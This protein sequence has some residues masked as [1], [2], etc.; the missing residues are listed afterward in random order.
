LPPFFK[1]PFHQ[2]H[3]I[4]IIPMWPI[5]HRHDVEEACDADDVEDAF[6]TD[7]NRRYIV[8]E[9]VM[10]EQ[11]YH[12]MLHNLH[13]VVALI[14]ETS[15]LFVD[16]FEPHAPTFQELY[17]LIDA[18]MHLSSYLS[19]RFAERALHW[20]D[21]QTIGDCIVEVLPQLRVLYLQH[22]QH[23]ALVEATL[24]AC[25]KN[26]DTSLLIEACIVDTRAI[27]CTGATAD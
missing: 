15:L 22:M 3:H 27:D 16:A 17:R 9:L 24:K 19:K 23:H 21:Q 7:R 18:S 2:Q 5:A 10:T 13:R 6:T 11:H 12:Q 26:P 14:L 8:D 4:T 25:K 20:H 1:H